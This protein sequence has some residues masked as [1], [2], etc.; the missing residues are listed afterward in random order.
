MIVR[1]WRGSVRREDSERYFEYLK[2]TGLTAYQHT[3]GNRGVMAL[4]L[5]VT[6]FFRGLPFAQ[7]AQDAATS[8]LKSRAARVCFTWNVAARFKQIPSASSG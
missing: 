3:P 2:Q 8:H 5:I 6:P 1:S 7:V 4:R